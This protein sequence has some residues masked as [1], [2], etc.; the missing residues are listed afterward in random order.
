MNIRQESIRRKTNEVDITGKLVIDGAGNYDISTGF[1]SLDHLLGLFA[2]HGLFDLTI[3]AKGDLRHHIVEDLGISIGR[4]FKAAL[5]DYSGIKRYAASSL[6]MDEV[7]ARVSLDLGGRDCF[8]WYA[9]LAKN[10][11]KENLDLSCGDLR[12]FL[13]ALTK[14]TKMNLFIEYLSACKEMD[15]HHLFEAI[16]KALGVALRQASSFD[17]LRKGVPSTKGIID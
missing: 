15:T 5:G 17:P 14:N 6:P 4:A 1:E 11:I 3:K 10:D 9:P 12:M 13:E 8:V 16:F 2:F 7:L